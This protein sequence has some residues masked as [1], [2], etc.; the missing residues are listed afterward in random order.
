M[1]RA[2]SHSVTAIRSVTFSGPILVS[3]SNV[4]PT[5]AVCS[6]VKRMASASAIQSTWVAMSSIRAQ[7]VSGEASIVVATS[8]L[9]ILSKPKVSVMASADP[10]PTPNPNAMKFTLDVTLDEMV[11]VRSADAAAGNPLAERIFAIPGVVMLFGTADFLTVSRE[12]GADWDAIVPAVVAVV[13][14]EL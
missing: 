3:Q 11:D 9:G 7:T 13:A 6:E 2:G 1:A 12:E 4:V 5:P 10:S 14:E 8:I